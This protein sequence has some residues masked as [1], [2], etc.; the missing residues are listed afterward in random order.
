MGWTI[1]RSQGYVWKLV[2]NWQL[3]APRRWGKLRDS[4]GSRR[5][6]FRL[7]LSGFLRATYITDWQVRQTRVPFRIDAHI[8][9]CP[10]CQLPAWVSSR[11]LSGWPDRKNRYPEGGQWQY[12]CDQRYPSSWG[13][14]RISGLRRRFPEGFG[15]RASV[16][17]DRATDAIS[18]SIRRTTRNHCRRGLRAGPC[19]SR[20]AAILVRQRC[21]H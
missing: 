8:S 14:L 15:C 18:R 20:L 7:F 10:N 4:A 19:I 12:R 6:T 3:A 1:T 21:C 17:L 11:W 2:R 5:R 9:Q 13:A 16:V